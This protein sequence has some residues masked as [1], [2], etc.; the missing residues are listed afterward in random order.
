[1]KETGSP[2]TSDDSVAIISSSGAIE[3][4]NIPKRIGVDGEISPFHLSGYPIRAGLEM[5]EGAGLALS[6]AGTRY[7]ALDVA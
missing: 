5:T 3:V 2:A 6:S 7:K 4:N 1:M